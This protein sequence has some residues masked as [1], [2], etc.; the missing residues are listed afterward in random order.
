M[1]TT[2]EKQFLYGDL[3][4]ILKPVMYKLMG[5]GNTI[6]AYLVMDVIQ[7]KGANVNITNGHLTAN[8]AIAKKYRHLKLLY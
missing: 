3:C 1:T 5:N 4:L 2:D 8:R 7:I 6:V